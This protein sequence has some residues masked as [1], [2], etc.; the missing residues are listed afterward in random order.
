MKTIYSLTLFLSIIFMMSACQE[1][2]DDIDSQ[3]NSKSISS[4][5]IYYESEEQGM[6]ELSQDQIENLIA[7]TLE[8]EAPIF[9]DLK[10]VKDEVGNASIKSMVESNGTSFSVGIILLPYGKKAY[11]MGKRCSCSGSACVL[12]IVDGLCSCSSNGGN[13]CTKIETVDI[14]GTSET[15]LSK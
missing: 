7:N 3:I 14:G 15:L 4:V 8:I 12:T 11:K 2:K 9:S 1:A 6:L 5:Q 10:V 13:D